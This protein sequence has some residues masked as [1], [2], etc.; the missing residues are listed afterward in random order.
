M[1]VL[2]YD[3]F[4]LRQCLMPR[5]AWDSVC[6]KSHLEFLIFLLLRTQFWDYRRVPPCLGLA[7]SATA[8]AK[9]CLG[10]L[11]TE[12]YLYKRHV[13]CISASFYLMVVWYSNILSSI[14]NMRLK[15]FSKAL[16]LSSK[17]DHILNACSSGQGILSITIHS[18]VFSAS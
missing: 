10:K 4:I 14:L 15:M 9:A 16:L 13:S 17:L 18:Y 6:N 2:S 7:V 12:S 11:S 1:N 8:Q 3:L 5:L